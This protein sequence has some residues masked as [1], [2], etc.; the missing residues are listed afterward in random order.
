MEGRVSD[1]LD[2]AYGRAPPAGRRAL[3]ANQAG[4][5]TDPLA[6]HQPPKECA[7]RTDGATFRATS[8][9]RDSV[10]GGALPAHEGTQ[11]KRTVLLKNR[12]TSALILRISRAVGQRSKSCGQ[13][14]IARPPCHRPDAH[15]RRDAGQWPEGHP[16]TDPGH[17]G[18]IDVGR[19]P[20][21]LPERGPRH[22]RLHP[23][24]RA[25]AV[26]G[27]RQARQGRHRQD[28]LPPRRKDER[29]HRHRLHDVLRDDSRERDGHGPHDRVGAH[30]QRRVRPE[31]G[32]GRADGR[33]QRAR[34]RGEPARV[35]GRGG[36]VGPRLPRPPVPLDR[37]RVQAGPRDP[38]PRPAVPS[39]PALLRAEQR[40]PGP[41]WRL[42][43]GGRDAARPR[44]VRGPEAGDAAGPAVAD[45]ERPPGARR[46]PRPRRGGPRPGG[47]EAAEGPAAEGRAGA[48]P[49]AGPRLGPVRTRRR[50]VPGNPPQRGRRPRLVGLRGGAPRED[51]EGPRGTDPVGRPDVPGRRSPDRRAVP[52]PGG[53]SVNLPDRTVLENG[54]VLLSHA[55]PSNPFIAFRGS[56]PAGVAAEGSDQGVAEFTSRLLLSG[57]RTMSAAK[58]ADRLEGIGATLEFHGGE[59]VLTFQGRCTRET[60]A[61]TVR[62]L[63]EC[64]A[65]P[66]F[67]P[68][69]IERVRGELLNDVRME[70]ND[71][72][73]PAV[74]ELAR[75]VFPKDHPYGRDPK[76]SESRI[77]RIRRGDIVSFHEAHVGPEGLIL[78]A[79]GDVDRTL[80]DDA[81]ATPLSR[82]R[83]DEGGPPAIP[84]PPP[85]RPGTGWIPMPHKTQVDVAIGAPGVPRPHA[86][87]YAL[88]LA[89][90]LF[91][92]IGLYGRLGRNLR[93]EQGLAYY[94]FSSLDARTAGGMWS[95]S[96]GVN[97]ANLGKAIESIR[98]E[99][100]RLR[101]EPFTRDEI[102]DG[103]DNQV[104]SLIVSL[105]RNAEVASELHRMEY[106][107]LGMDFLE[108]YPE[109]IADLTEERVRDVARKY[110]LASAS[111]MVVAGPVGRTRLRL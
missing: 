93:D 70:A 82:L 96:A 58:L 108:R 4:A 107:G 80:L 52:R 98:G 41:R 83:G 95:I 45:R 84:P 57:T 19:L 106:Y 87:Y 90:L 3:P 53:P 105:E 56:V 99:M 65:R 43:S 32:R 85:H 34:G 20:D 75:L 44:G 81:I 33:H 109:V 38:G 39:L 67:P 66:T 40:L 51:R 94:A 21:R 7:S 29:L 6:I 26:Q 61:E 8:E 2:R 49:R 35:R 15:P 25:H 1:S 54:A 9:P 47:R 69:E 10:P 74:R 63:V 89:N 62:I 50:H 91:G 48:R 88:N 111:S 37:D 68:K 13:V 27:R 78:A 55:L 36:V 28:D 24:G 18:A 92:R 23:L 103:K 79:T 104:S 42:R 46:L 16:P 76:G 11:R 110:F 86:D 101:A 31:R 60:A 100:D 30:A 102:R 77:R 59:E 71:T 14:D 64:L 17:A 73:T 97:P 72:R 12:P 5:R 22:D